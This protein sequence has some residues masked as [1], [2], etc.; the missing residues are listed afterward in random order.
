MIW[1][2][3]LRR[4]FCR[5]CDSCSEVQ[6]AISAFIMSFAELNRAWIERSEPAA[7]ADVDRR[8]GDQG[9]LELV[10]DSAVIGDGLVEEVRHVERE[11]HGGTNLIRQPEIRDG[12]L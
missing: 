2:L 9:A 5:R 11:A 4:P 3:D 6:G 8:A 10:L 7:D 1:Q 12:A